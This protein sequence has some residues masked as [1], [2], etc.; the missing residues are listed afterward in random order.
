MNTELYDY[1]TQSI[2]A[3]PSASE[4]TDV[5]KLVDSNISHAFRQLHC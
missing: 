3:A 1:G 5:T 2:P 4:V